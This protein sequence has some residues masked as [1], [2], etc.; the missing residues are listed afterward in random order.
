MKNYFLKR[1]IKQAIKQT[2]NT[3]IHRM[4]EQTFEKWNLN[5]NK[6][7]QR[8]CHH[9]HRPRWHYCSPPSAGSWRQRSF[10]QGPSHQS[11]RINPNRTLPPF[12]PNGDQSQ[13]T[14]RRRQRP[15]PCHHSISPFHVITHPAKPLLQQ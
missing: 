12:F 4:R 10:F 15:L 7:P 6:N 8:L 11:L 1:I 3:N 14:S 2:L 13:A 5:N 9:H